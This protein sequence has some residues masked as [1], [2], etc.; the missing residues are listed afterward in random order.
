MC[1]S[2]LGHAHKG[3]EIKLGGTRALERVMRFFVIPPFSTSI[4][5]VKSYALQNTC[6]NDKQSF[7]KFFTISQLPNVKVYV[8]T[9]FK[10]TFFRGLNIIIFF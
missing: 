7:F 5:I 2:S 6:Y 4:L 8:N 3:R 1:V 10:F 9:R